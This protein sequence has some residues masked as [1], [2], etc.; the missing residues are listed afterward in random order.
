MT[1]QI[2]APIDG[3]VVP[4][5]D[6]PDPVFAEAVV[7]P[8][9]AIDP[10]DATTLAVAAPLDGTIVS[11]KPHAFVIAAADGRGILVHLGIDTVDLSGAGFTLR[12]E[13]GQ[14]VRAGDV[15]VDWETQPA[16]DAGKSLVVP[17]VVLEAEAAS[18]TTTT[19]AAVA[20]GDPLIEAD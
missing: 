1:L 9:T 19:A 5:A 14:A 7:G 8:G 16:R 2:S 20:V 6:V 12:A 13:K 3:A 15:L 10:G 18:L 4:L 11:L 17:V